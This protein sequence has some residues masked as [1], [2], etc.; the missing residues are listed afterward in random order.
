VAAKFSEDNMWYR[1][2]VE[3]VMGGANCKALVYFA[4]YGN[5]QHV[6]FNEL[7]PLPDKFAAAKPFAHEYALACVTMPPV[8]NYSI[9]KNFYKNGMSI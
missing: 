6:P 4:D 9:I 1:A 2:K 7:A 5:R 8:W 3:K